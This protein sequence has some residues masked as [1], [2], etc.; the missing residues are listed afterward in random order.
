MTTTQKNNLK[1]HANRVLPYILNKLGVAYTRRSDGLIQSCC[2]CQQHGGDGNNPTAFS[3]RMDIGKWVCWTHHCEE[4]RGNDILGLVSSVLGSDFRDTCKWLEDALNEDGI[5]LSEEAGI[6][7]NAVVGTKLHSHVPLKED[8]VRFLK[9]DPEYLL[10]RGF[11]KDILRKYQVGFWFRPGTFM[12]DRVVF[13]IRDHEGFLVGYT[14]RTV[15]EPEYF[16]T[17]G[18][19]YR[20]WLHGRNYHLY[21]KN[22]ELFTSS[23]LFNLYNSKQYL[24]SHNRMIL[25]EGTTDGMKLQEAGI[26]NWCSTLSSTLCPAQR[27]LLVQAGVT[28]LYIAY[29][30][31]VP[32]GPKQKRAGEEGWKR[33]QRVV[34]DLFRLH[35]VPLPEG[36]DCADHNTKELQEIFKDIA[37]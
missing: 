35:R 21:P 8:N 3:W 16:E 22:G 34:G 4:E 24:G 15:H 1:N 5:D 7:E 29:D 23:I 12:H 36:K 18:I 20:K 2:P 33:A 30:N 31:D 14:G 17:K 13:P 27:T 32:K 10:N 37:C 26:H 6:P 11:D 19:P 9:S 25:L 28:D